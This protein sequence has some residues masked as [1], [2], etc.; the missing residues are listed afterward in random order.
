MNTKNAKL[1]NNVGHALE[2]KGKFEDALRYFH[3]AVEAQPDD[4][5]AHINVGRTFNFLK[6]F[7]EAENAYIKVI[8]FIFKVFVLIYRLVI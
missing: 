3:A 8:F 6:R 5:G 7:E 4:I 2:G 1:F